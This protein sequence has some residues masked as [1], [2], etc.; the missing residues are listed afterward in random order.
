MFKY[1][2]DDGMNTI[3]LPMLRARGELALFLKYTKP[4]ASR[5][6]A[7]SRHHA[8]RDIG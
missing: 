2:G 7:T 6:L 3:D 8:I 4:Y 5:S 1:D